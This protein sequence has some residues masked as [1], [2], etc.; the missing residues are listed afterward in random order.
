MSVCR[1]IHTGE[2]H[3]TMQN[4]SSD[5]GC[6]VQSENA[7]GLLTIRRGLMALAVVLVLVFVMAW[8][9]Q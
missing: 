9:P 5:P 1:C 6:H 2:T 3:V 4:D 7:T 8:T